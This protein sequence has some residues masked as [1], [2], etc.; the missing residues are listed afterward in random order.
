MAHKPTSR[1]KV[2]C[3]FGPRHTARSAT[4]IITPESQHGGCSDPHPHEID[5][6]LREIDFT[7]LQDLS[8]N[9]NTSSTNL[10]CDG[11]IEP[12]A[13][14]LQL[15]QKGK[16]H[17]RRKVKCHFGPYRR[18]GNDD[19]RIT[20]RNDDPPPLSDWRSDNQVTAN[21][22]FDASQQE[23]GD[24][25]PIPSPGLVQVDSSVTFTPPTSWTRPNT[26]LKQ[27]D[28]FLPNGQSDA[29]E[30]SARQPPQLRVPPAD[31]RCHSSFASDTERLPHVR[32]YP[33]DVWLRE[34]EGAPSHPEDDLELNPYA[35]ARVTLTLPAGPNRTPFD[36][37]KASAAEAPKPN[38]KR[39][40]LR[41]L[42]LTEEEFDAKVA[43]EVDDLLRTYGHERQL[44]HLFASSSAAPRVLSKDDLWTLFHAT[45]FP[46][47]GSLLGAYWWAAGFGATRFNFEMD[48]TPEQIELLNAYD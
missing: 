43:A 33:D 16:L 31:P 12:Q 46:T 24:R 32:R 25:S 15:K 30:S 4:N 6:L 5:D 1:P 26:L 14:D 9:R 17:S 10:S 41:R 40:I 18:R 44:E 37:Y 34:D 27:I 21:T 8:P 28:P 2:R 13:I 47:S 22:T 19:L 39:F 48:W 7:R 23:Q 11:N 45:E 35:P 36:I 42:G 20:P 38:P 3:K 29:A